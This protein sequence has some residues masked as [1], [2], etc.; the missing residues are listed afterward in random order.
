MRGRASCVSG[1]R[2]DHALLEQGTIEWHSGTQLDFY[3]QEPN[4]TRA[5]EA[6]TTHL[7]ETLTPA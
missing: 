2:R 7:H 3:D 5:I 4:V 6:A 1:S